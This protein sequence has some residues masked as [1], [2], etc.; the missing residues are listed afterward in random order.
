MSET[1]RIVV[2]GGGIVGA[3]AAYHLAREGASVLIAEGGQT[4]TATA[5]GAGII[6]PWTVPA[7]DPSYRLAAEGAAYY[8]ELIALLAED[9]QVHTGYAQVGGVCVAEDAARLDL[10]EAQLRARLGAAPQIGQIEVLPAGGARELFPP[11]ASALGA[12]WVSGAARVDGRAMRD[13][14]LGAA[15]AHGARLVPG[16]AS[17]TTAGGRVTGVTA[18]SE[19][20]EADV[21]LA[22]AGAWTALLCQGVAPDLPIGPQKGQI[23]HLDLPGRD[24]SGWPVVLPGSDPYLLAFPGSRVVL[25]ATRERAGFDDRVTA[26]GISGLLAG[27]L[28]VAPGLA[29]AT[30]AEIRVGFRPVT[31]DGDP[32]LGPLSEGLVVA[33]GNGA[34]GLTAGPM[35][36][37]LAASLALAEH[38]PDYI[39]RFHPGRTIGAHDVPNSS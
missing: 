21:V 1:A 31:S 3:S 13:S 32:L 16:T 22:A 12:V 10:I 29:D 36:G 11:L 20:I 9:G 18:G 6:C 24:T 30:L 4:G 8:P 38:V 5:A 23:V 26:G 35:T 34:E 28:A 27:A 25:G 33:A 19:R 14:L 39:T 15:V 7:D 17:L 37:R 2:V